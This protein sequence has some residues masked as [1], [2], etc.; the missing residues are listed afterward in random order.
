[1]RIIFA[2]GGTA[3]HIN[4]ALA[5]ADKF[6]SVFPES[7]IL[8]VGAPDGMEATLVKKAGYNFRSF[9][10]AGLQRKITPKNILRNAKA[11]YYYITARANAKKLLKEFKPDVVVGTG[12]YVS[13][14]VL[15]SAAKLGIRHYG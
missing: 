9:H 6:R 4:P 11:A 13:A 12:G 10:M 7:E 14:P 5:I 1:M 15:L 3:G 2:A 8:F